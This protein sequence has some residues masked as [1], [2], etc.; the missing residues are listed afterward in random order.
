MLIGKQHYLFNRRCWDRRPMSR[1]LIVVYHEVIPVEFGG[2][3]GMLSGWWLRA[4]TRSLGRVGPAI[5]NVVL[6]DNYG[7]CMSI[8]SCNFIGVGPGHSARHWL[9][10]RGLGVNTEFCKTVLQCLHDAVCRHTSEKWCTAIG[11][12]TKTMH[13][14]TNQ[15]HIFGKQHSIVHTPSII[16]W[17]FAMWLLRVATI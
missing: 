15:K 2:E 13:L 3:K 14:L 17:S 6:E 12:C 7:W 4:S 11:F 9:I 10:P 16:L 8:L 5:K 1:P